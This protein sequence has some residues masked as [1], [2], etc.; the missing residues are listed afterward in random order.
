MPPSITDIQRWVSD[1]EQ[2]THPLRERMEADYQRWILKEYNPDDKS[3]KAYTSN[4]P[5]ALAEKVISWITSADLNIRIQLRNQVEEDRKRADKKERFLIGSLRSADAR[6]LRRIQPPLKDQLAWYSVLRGWLM[7]R[8]T[9]AKHPDGSTYV[10][11]TPW[12]P[13][14]VFYEAG[15]DGPLW[16]CHRVNLSWEQIKGEYGVELQGG[17]RSLGIQVYDWYDNEQNIVFAEGE[18]LKPP[19]PHVIPGM[20]IFLGSVATSPPVQALGSEGNSPDV[21]VAD[22][23][24]SVYATD[25]RIYDINNKLLSAVL[26]LATRSAKTPY[27]LRSRSGQKTLEGS[28]FMDGA[29]IPLAEGE[30]LELIE[31]MK[32]APDMAPLLAVI[33]GELQRGALPHL[34]YGM[35]QFQLSGFAMNTLRQGVGAVLAPRLDAVKRAYKQICD[36]LVAQYESGAFMPV[37]SQGFLAQ[38]QWFDE[39]VHPTDIV[40]GGFIELNLMA[41]LPQDEMARF[42]MAQAAREGATPLF[43]DRYIRDDILG[44][45][46]VDRIEDMIK[47]QVAERATPMLTLWTLR[48][49]MLER[50]RMDLVQQLEGEMMRMMV[51]GLGVLPGGGSVGGSTNGAGNGAGK[52]SMRPEVASAASRGI[53]PPAPGPEQVQVPPPG[54][55]RPGAIMTPEQRLG[56]IG[57]AG[58][59]G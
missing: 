47:E 22:Y 29:E 1:K 40:D 49:A 10:D 31:M 33:S 20:P 5:R 8:S 26:T 6:L 12:D 51:A 25:R 43:P 41:H 35:I 3:L 59:R 17:S 58:P 34:V 57:L 37:R 13:L 53:P 38:R 42:T 45:Q 39:E 14:H 24:E 19:T 9:L 7:G 32:S 44:V 28:P 55:P 2:E 4:E 30:D 11:V 15:A 48:K 46:D 56:R 52:L 54:A 23:G 16:V 27:K 50:G 18:L 36:L 21:N